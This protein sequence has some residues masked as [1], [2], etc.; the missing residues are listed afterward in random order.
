MVTYYECHI[1]LEGN[2]NEIKTHVEELKW[3]FSS[4][5]GDIILGD[6]VKCYATRHFN[7]KLSFTKVFEKLMD[8]AY[9]LENKGIK[10]IRRKVEHVLYDDR[11]VKVNCNG[12]CIECHLDDLKGT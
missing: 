12:G 10:V 9:E 5:S 1:T 4:I 2:S 3:K 6:G 11:S 8:T 7:T